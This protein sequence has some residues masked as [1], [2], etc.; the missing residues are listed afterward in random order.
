MFINAAA[1][2]DCVVYNVPYFTSMTKEILIGGAI[3]I[4]SGRIQ[5]Y[6]SGAGGGGGDLPGI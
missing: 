3:R 1:V 4:I 5:I 6:H 2:N